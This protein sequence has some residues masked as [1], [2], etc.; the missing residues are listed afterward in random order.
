MTIYEKMI[1]DKNYLASV[2]DS[3]IPL[4]QE[5]NEWY[6]KYKCPHQMTCLTLRDDPDYSCMDRSTCQE[7]IALWLDEE[8]KEV[9]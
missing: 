5:V 6:C 2:L 1:S 9:I 8:F 3:D 4:W 7:R